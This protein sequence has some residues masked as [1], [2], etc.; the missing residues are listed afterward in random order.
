MSPI[1]ADRDTFRRLMFSCFDARVTVD[2]QPQ[3]HLMKQVSRQSLLSG[4]LDAL[5]KNISLHEQAAI[6][7]ACT[8]ARI[9]PKFYVARNSVNC[10]LCSHALMFTRPEPKWRKEKER[11]RYIYIYSQKRLTERNER[12]SNGGGCAEDVA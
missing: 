3:H 8:V 2:Y 7:P 9:Q 10:V 5:V 12:G 4:R 1:S 6:C 11:E